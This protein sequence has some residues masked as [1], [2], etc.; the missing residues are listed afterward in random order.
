MRPNRSITVSLPEDMAELV[1]KK[2]SSG[3]FANESEVVAEGLRYLADHDA[4][5]EQWLRDE[6]VPTLRAHDADPSR[7]RTVEETRKEL[8]EYIRTRDRRSIGA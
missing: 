4:E 7:A 5:I 3:E 8:E 6:V 1:E 2:V